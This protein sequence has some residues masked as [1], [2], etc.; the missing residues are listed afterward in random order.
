MAYC[1]FREVL[2][3]FSPASIR[4][5]QPI[6]VTPDFRLSSARGGRT[7]RSLGALHPVITPALQSFDRKLALLAFV[8]ESATI[9]DMVRLQGTLPAWR[10]EYQA[11][12]GCTAS[13]RVESV[14][15]A[16]SPVAP[17]SRRM[18]AGACPLRLRALQAGRPLL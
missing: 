15:D 11:R 12:R 17:A 8:D 1:S 4:R 5:L 14:C 3:A 7:S 18:A 10:P 6:V 9:I 16:R 2:A 13:K